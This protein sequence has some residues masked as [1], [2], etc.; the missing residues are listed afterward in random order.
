MPAP[1]HDFYIDWGRDGT[2][3]HA[4]ADVTAI[5]EGVY[6]T[7]GMTDES[8]AMAQPATG[9]FT[10]RNDSGQW[11][12]DNVGAAYYSLLKRGVLI[13][14][15]MTYGGTTQQMW[16]GRVVSA[17][18][19]SFSAFASNKQVQ[20][21]ADDWTADM[22][23]S[24]YA[25]KLREDVRIDTELTTVLDSGA[26]PMP[27][28]A[29][30]WVL[31]YSTLETGDNPTT[32]L[33]MSS[34]YDFDTAQE[35]PEYLGD[36]SGTDVAVSAYGYISDLTLAEMGGIFFY[37]P[38]STKFRFHDRQHDLRTSAVTAAL[39]KSL[40][41]YEHVAGIQMPPMTWGSKAVTSVAASYE[42]RTVG[43]AESIVWNAENVPRLIRAGKS[44]RYTARYRDP[45]SLIPCG[46]KDVEYPQAGTDYTANT[47]ANGTG[48]D[49]I[50]S[51]R[52]LCEMNARGARLSITNAHDTSDLYLTLA[53]LRG[54]PLVITD[55][56]TVEKQ[57]ADNIGAH[58]LR[59]IAID[60]PYASDEETVESFVSVLLAA[61]APIARF[62]TVTFDAR[63]HDTLMQ[64]ARDVDIGERISVNLSGDS[65][66]THNQDYIVK[67]FTYSL[68]GDT[69]TLAVTWVVKPTSRALGWILADDERGV[70]ESTTVIVF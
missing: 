34:Y 15:R 13:R 47:A 55:R 66:T 65:W 2:Y 67:G 10:L 19:P 53:Q 59:H 61:G 11:L 58:G 29:S 41:H 35:T 69:P 39:T 48:T 28:A 45:E 5:V 8:Q 18:V 54:T 33:D 27:Y 37:D 60:V 17:T 24:T 36:E 30:G 26:A 56:R 12:M 31:G 46:A 9:T 64:A 51:V 62:P 40:V 63:A 1:T 21:Q 20:L 25:P 14:W 70:L 50:D 16:A 43:A 49:M 68:R 4:S 44:A 38:R 32:L 57:N 6:C 23:A 42:L 3:G 52:M 7:G 22:A